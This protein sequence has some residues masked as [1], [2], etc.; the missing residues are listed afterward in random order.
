M[1][2]KTAHYFGTIAQQVEQLAVNQWVVGSS[3]TGPVLKMLFG[4]ENHF[5]PL[6]VDEGRNR[7]F[8]FFA[9]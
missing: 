8:S 6:A 3:P 7:R 5:P 4:S 1:L 2:E 9:E